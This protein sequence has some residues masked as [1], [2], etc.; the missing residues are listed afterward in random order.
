M[1]PSDPTSPTASG[2]FPEG[3]EMEKFVARRQQT[4]S[5]WRWLLLSALIIAVLSLI[6][7]LYDVVNKS[8]GYTILQAK[9]NPTDML[10]KTQEQAMLNASTT[11]SS[12]DDN[13]LVKGIAKNP[14]ALG[15]FGYAYYQQNKDKLNLLSIEGVTPSQETAANGTY[16]LARPLYIYSSQTALQ[17]PYVAG[18]INY[19]LSHANE[20]AEEVGYFP[21]AVEALEASTQTW[22]TALNL[23]AEA[24]LP[25]V[26]PAEYNKEDVLTISGSSTVY[27]LSRQMA[28]AFRKAGFTGG[29]KIDSVGTSAGFELFCAGK[30]DVINASRPINRAELEACQKKKITPLEFA[31]AADAIAV[32][33]NKENNF[34]KNL[35]L[36]QMQD[37]FTTA[38]TWN[39]LDPGWPQTTLMRFIPGAA[40][41]TLDFFA[42]HVFITD[43]ETALQDKDLL[44]NVLAYNLTPG[45]LNALDAEKPL[46]ERTTEEL[47]ELVTVEVL[48]PQV[49]EVWPL[50]ESLFNQ[51]EIKAYAATVPDSILDFRN[52]VSLDFITSPQSSDALSAGVQTAILGSLWIIAVTIL[53]AFPIG[54]GAAIYLEEY[55]RMVS[56][57]RLRRLNSMIQTNINNLAGVPSIIYGILGLTVFVRVLEPI[58]SGTAFGLADPTTANGRTILSASLTM[59]L[60]VLPLIIVSSQEA[61]RAVPQSLRQA[62]MGLGGTRWQTIWAHVLPSALPGILTGN[63]LAFSRAMG[64]TAPLVVVGASTYITTNPT[65]VFSK[66][67]TLPIQIYQWTSRPQ[68]EWQFVAGAAIL[69]LMVL[70]LMLNSVAIYLRNRFRKRRLA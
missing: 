26:D 35:T 5:V 30:L 55:A 3:D 70:L 59:A 13:E 25:P 57:P 4:G 2:K 34:A 49:Y 47:A 53:V 28:V 68:P 29:I 19:Y 17:K 8:F 52:W 1:N 18:Y 50:V 9:V 48:Q 62:G 51:A 36:A 33:A 6:A 58:T 65:S 24:G 22:F 37:A 10:I 31:V 64:E 39:Q 23:P 44:L 54:V 66:F 40:S 61:I 12:E 14:E 67:T 16:P 11:V 42:D 45:R 20:V 60:L 41:G 43:L 56:S 63:I 15:F 69:V 7:L 32:V 38:E 46:E 27:P 21:P